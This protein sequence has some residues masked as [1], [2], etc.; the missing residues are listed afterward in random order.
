MNWE[1]AK[2]VR[3]SKKQ[4]TPKTLLK[5]CNAGAARLSK[6]PPRRS[7]QLTGNDAEHPVIIDEVSERQAVL[8]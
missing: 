5:G 3:T 6:T 7:L 1:E 2:E 8:S 4:A